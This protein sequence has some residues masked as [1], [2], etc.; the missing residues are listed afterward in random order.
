[1]LPQYL[2][3][4]RHTRWLSPCVI[5]LQET[6]YPDLLRMTLNRITKL[7]ADTN[8]HTVMDQNTTGA[9]SDVIPLVMFMPNTPVKRPD[10]AAVFVSHEGG[11]VAHVSGRRRAK[12][13]A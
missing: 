5:L 11:Q 3:V 13:R 12:S 4:N 9:L 8:V 2:H 10:A 1:M 7:T 6:K